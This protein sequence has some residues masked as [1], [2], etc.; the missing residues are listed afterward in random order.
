MTDEQHHAIA[1]LERRYEDVRTLQLLNGLYAA[2]YRED[3]TRDVWKIDRAGIGS[4]RHSNRT[5]DLA[6]AH[7]P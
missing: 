1:T 2:C 3:G 5:E 4:L 6:E 7:Q